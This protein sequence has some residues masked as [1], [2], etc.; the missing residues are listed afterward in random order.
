MQHGMA[1]DVLELK[2]SK[3][4]DANLPLQ[5]IKGMNNVLD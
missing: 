4:K 2:G 1:Q 3:D 5:L